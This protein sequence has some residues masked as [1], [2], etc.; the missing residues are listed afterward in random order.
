MS[1]ELSTNL[2]ATAHKEVGSS[3]LE[4]AIAIFNSKPELVRICTDSDSWSEYEEAKYKLGKTE[5][6]IRI[7]YHK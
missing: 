5:I 1:T 7:V 6:A 2:I 4:R 3:L